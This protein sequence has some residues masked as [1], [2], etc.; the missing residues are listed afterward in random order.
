[1]RRWLLSDQ[2][3][4]DETDGEIITDELFTDSISIVFENWI[5]SGP[6]MSIMVLSAG[7]VPITVGGKD[8]IESDVKGM[9]GKDSFQYLSSCVAEY[10]YWPL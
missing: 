1:M 8:G 2:V 7:F 3:I 9:E 5:W 10:E 4:V 6:L